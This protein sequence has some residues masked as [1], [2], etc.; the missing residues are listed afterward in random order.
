MGVSLLSAFGRVCLEFSARIFRTRRESVAGRRTET[1]F[2]RE[3]RR[4]TANGSTL[5]RWLL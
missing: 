1:R 4:E 5:A 2:A 3:G